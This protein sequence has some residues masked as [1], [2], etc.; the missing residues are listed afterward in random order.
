MSPDQT[1]RT[2]TLLRPAEW[3]D[4][5]AERRIRL[6]SEW[7]R[8]TVG[9]EDQAL[10]ENVQRG[11]HQLGFQQGWYVNDPD[12]HNISEHALRYFHERYLALMNDVYSPKP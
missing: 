9:P 2:T 8:N 1:T 3:P 5:D 12:A 6:R 7:S 11:M 10:C 4:A